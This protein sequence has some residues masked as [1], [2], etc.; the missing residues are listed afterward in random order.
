MVTVMAVASPRHRQLHAWV[1][2]GTSA[3]GD[4]VCHATAHGQFEEGTG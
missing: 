4:H 3:V 2:D 1:P